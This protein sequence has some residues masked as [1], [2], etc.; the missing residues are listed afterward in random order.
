SQ[1]SAEAREDARC[2]RYLLRA[3]WI[4]AT[5]TYLFGEERAPIPANDDHLRE[6]LDILEGLRAIEGSLGD[7]RSEYLRAV[8]M[9]RQQREHA[10]REIWRDLGRETAFSDPRRVVRHH[11]WSDS[12]GRPRLFHGR[13][14]RDDLGPGR[15]RVQVE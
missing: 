4:E 8:L 12:D 7:P 10:A 1:H 14:V 15:A 6:I 13:V 5:G 11:V 2:L 3:R 9:W